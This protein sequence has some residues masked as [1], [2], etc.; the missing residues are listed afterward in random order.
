MV[1]GG[2]SSKGLSDLIFLEGPENEFSYAQILLYYKDNLDKFKGR[3]Y[4]EQD[5]ATPHTSAANKVLIGYYILNLFIGAFIA[6]CASPVY[7]EYIW[8]E[9]VW[10]MVNM[11]RF[12]TF[13]R[14]GFTVVEWGGTEVK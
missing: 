7:I 11:E 8:N 6:F 10:E 3:I 2:I 9:C 1:A 13:E 12:E 14:N 4:F 5:G